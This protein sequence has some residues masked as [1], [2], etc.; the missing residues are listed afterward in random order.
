MWSKDFS[1]ARKKIEKSHSSFISEFFVSQTVVFIFVFDDTKLYNKFLFVCHLHSDRDGLLDHRSSLIILIS[2]LS[3]LT[4]LNYCFIEFWKRRVTIFSIYIKTLYLSSR[5]MTCT[6]FF[7][8]ITHLYR[9]FE[10]TVGYN[11]FDICFSSIMTSDSACTGY[12]ELYIVCIWNWPDYFSRR[13]IDVQQYIHIYI[14]IYIMIRSAIISCLVSTVFHFPLSAVFID[15]LKRRSDN[16]SSSSN[17]SEGNLKRIMSRK[18]EISFQVHEIEYLFCISLF[19]MTRDYER[20][21][22]KDD[23]NWKIFW[24]VSENVSL[25]EIGHSRSTF[26]GIE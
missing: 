8:F 5:R 25:L 6:S 23:E 19:D 17:V 18:N 3:F 10:K 14:Y 9:I 16:S 24:S 4:S 13:E 26:V 2:S 1:S 15:F 22:N 11:Y 7:H 20:I 12:Y 21:V